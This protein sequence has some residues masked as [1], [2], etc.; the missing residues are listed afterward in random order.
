M[1]VRYDKRI[2][3]L[4]REVAALE[5]K[6]EAIEKAAAKTEVIANENKTTWDYVKTAV[7][8]FLKLVTM[9]LAIKGGAELTDY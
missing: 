3:R 1:S 7:T 2:D 5:A 9:A 8:V 6:I 4:V